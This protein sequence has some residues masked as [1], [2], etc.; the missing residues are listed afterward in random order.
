MMKLEFLSL[1][2]VTLRTYYALKA[3]AKMKENKSTAYIMPNNK[4]NV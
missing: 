2:S 4:S 3:N 1:M